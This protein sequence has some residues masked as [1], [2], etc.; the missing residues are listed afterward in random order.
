MGPDR[1]RILLQ[2]VL[3][4]L[5]G[6]FI[7]PHTGVAHRYFLEDEGVTRCLLQREPER[8]QGFVEL[9]VVKKLLALTVIVDGFSLCATE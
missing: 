2:H 4:R 5:D 3:V 8:R 1:L 7:H 9:F 6:L